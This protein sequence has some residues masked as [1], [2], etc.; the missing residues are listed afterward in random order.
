[1]SEKHRQR[2]VEAQSQGS[3]TSIAIGLCVMLLHGQAN[4][5]TH[6]IVASLHPPTDIATNL[7]VLLAVSRPRDQLLIAGISANDNEKMVLFQVSASTLLDSSLEAKAF[8]VDYI[9][10]TDHS[11]P[12]ESAL[13]FDGRRER[14]FVGVGTAH[15]G[16]GQIVAIE[17]GKKQVALFDGSPNEDGSLETPI[18]FGDQASPLVGIGAAM[19]ID[20]EGSSLIFGWDTVGH[21]PIMYEVPRSMDLDDWDW[22]ML[23]SACRPIE[24]SDPFDVRRSRILG[25]ACSA[26]NSAFVGCVGVG[27]SGSIEWFNRL[28]NGSW[29]FARQVKVEGAED[30]D[31][32]GSAVA[33]SDSMLAVGS[34][35]TRIVRN[36]RSWQGR[37]RNGAVRVYK[38][39]NANSKESR[40]DLVQTIHPPSEKCVAFGS[41]IDI[42]G[43]TLVISDP[44]MDVSATA[45]R[46]RVFIYRFATGTG[47]KHIDTL[48]GQT[49]AT[50]AYGYR[51]QLVGDD[52]LAV[53]D[54]MHE[55]EASGE[56]V[57]GFWLVKIGE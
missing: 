36:S 31:G 7:G 1:M 16:K 35:N 18:E 47:F 56:P 29:K 40:L 28:E 12:G 52:L 23:D 17:R 4:S 53:V 24:K 14:S 8:A 30:A 22:S 20:E 44:G 39:S 51:V 15:S 38:M 21:R 6:E 13:I 2:E 27:E 45:G 55:A 41:V 9:R 11:V 50:G 26:G 43:R 54:P 33:A 10:S 37:D 5:A 34:G 42:L 25:Y 57:G 46:G 32:F 48:I 19:A 49:R 3:G